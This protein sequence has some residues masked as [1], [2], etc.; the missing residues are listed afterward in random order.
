MTHRRHLLILFVALFGLLSPSF[1]AGVGAVA[2]SAAVPAITMAD[3]A[4]PAVPQ[5]K[6]C[7]KQG[8]KRVLPCHPD[9][10]ILA[11]AP[12]ASAWAPAGRRFPAAEPLRRLLVPAADPPPPRRG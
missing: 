8:G 5:Y 12:E 7:E 2:A 3:D 9:L 1:A 6:P 11:V 4:G 10:G